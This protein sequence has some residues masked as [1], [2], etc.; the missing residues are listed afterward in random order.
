MEIHLDLSDDSDEALRRQME[1]KSKSSQSSQ[2]NAGSPR[3]KSGSGII[4][5]KVEIKTPPG[6]QDSI[7]FT[8]SRSLDSKSVFTYRSGESTVVVSN[9]KNDVARPS[10]PS[11][12]SSV[13]S[14]RRERKRAESP[15]SSVWSLFSDKSLFSEKTPSMH[16]IS[17]S[18]PRIDFADD[19]NAFKKKATTSPESMK[20]EESIAEE[21]KAIDCIEKFPA[22]VNEEVSNSGP[23]DP[24]PLSNSHQPPIMDGRMDEVADAESTVG[25]VSDTDWSIDSNQYNSTKYGY[26]GYGSGP[27]PGKK[28]HKNRQ[29]LKDLAPP[30]CQILHGGYRHT[31]LYWLFRLVITLFCGC[32][33]LIGMIYS[34]DIGIRLL[35]AENGRFSFGVYGAGLL[36]YLAIESIFASL[37]NRRVEKQAPPT[38]YEETATKTIALQISAY[39]EDPHYFRECLMGAMNMKYPRDKFKVICCIDGNEADSVYM[40]QIFNDVVRGNGHDPA[41]FRWDYNFHELPEGLNDSDNGVSTLNECIEMNQFVCLMQ[42]WGGKREVMYTAFKVLKEKADYVQVCDSDTQLDSRAMVELAWILDSQPNTGAVGGDVRIW[43]SGDSFVSFL[44]SL[45]YWMAFNIE[46]ACQS[47]FG[48]VSCISGPIGLYRMSLIN[49]I[50]DLWSDQRFLGHVCT[51]GDDRHLTNRILQ[52]GY[53]TKYTQRSFCKTETPSTYLRWLSQQIRWTKSYYRE[54]LF[55]SM[56]WHK[57]HL[58]MACEAIFSGAF[59]FLIMYTMIRIT[60]SGELWVLIHLLI[61]I[62]LV[63]LLKGLFASLVRRDPV[64]IF[65]SLYSSLYVSSLL[66]S[67][68]FAILTIGKKSWGTS[69]RKNI[70]TNYNPLIPVSTWVLTISSGVIYSAIANDYMKE[71]EIAFLGI[72]IGVYA[73]YWLLMVVLWKLRL[74]KHHTTKKMIVNDSIIGS[75]TNFS[76]N[77]RPQ[78]SLEIRDG[79]VDDDAAGREAKAI[80]A[81]LRDIENGRHLPNPYASKTS[82]E[83]PPGLDEAV[84]RLSA[85]SSSHGP[86]SPSVSSVYSYDNLIEDIRRNEES[87]GGMND[88]SIEVIKL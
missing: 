81:N 79:V 32:G 49:K 60:W 27:P 42:K 17:E 54:W 7:H 2:K 15:T 78:I 25:T 22:N 73:G 74:Q 65:T 40:A 84:L 39:Q 64:M 48:C 43:N 8:T 46:R 67:K 3:K 37:E 59:P 16:S 30:E 85:S 24:L 57:H 12:F 87:A 19:N 63:G 71:G 52:M 21:N 69:G 70:L 20:R 82:N 23:I 47:Y 88:R 62:Q 13:V 31:K 41:F 50:V 29:E 86:I 66:P 18:S 4:T 28:K 38:N 44:S 58:W 36:M 45:R 53:A 35:E 14:S 75:R 5:K 76:K 61:I 11:G 26:A 68:L 34:Y 51:F 56:W 6:F 72:G 80:L 10:S 9:K 77:V 55:N 33:A 83:G 1:G